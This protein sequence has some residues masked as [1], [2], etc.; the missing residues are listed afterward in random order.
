MRWRFN[1][2]AQSNLLATDDPQGLPRIWTAGPDSQRSCGIALPTNDAGKYQPLTPQLTKYD[3]SVQN[4]RLLRPLP[5]A[6][7]GRGAPGA[8]FSA[9]VEIGPLDALGCVVII[10]LAVGK[11]PGKLRRAAWLI[12]LWLVVSLLAATVWLWCDAGNTAAVQH[13]V[14]SGWYQ[15]FPQGLILTMRLL[16]LLLM[17]V[18]LPLWLFRFLRWTVRRLTKKPA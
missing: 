6:W 17:L 9:Y 18:I 3:E 12:A 2:T 1:T 5:W 8:V 13:Y 4:P 14:W 16:W 10:G 7:P 15:V 11:R